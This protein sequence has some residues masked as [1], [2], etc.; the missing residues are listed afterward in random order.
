[1]KKMDDLISRQAAIDFINAGHL[2]NP[3]EPRWSDNE[4]MNFLKSRPPAEI[5]EEQAIDKLHETGWMQNHDKEMTNSRWIPCK[6]RL[7]E[8][9]GT[10]LTTT[11]KG[12][13]RVNHFHGK[14]WGYSND[15]VAWMPLPAPAEVEND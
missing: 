12:A 10:Y 15:A 7:P 2:V 4:V 11:I 13:V 1:M 5:T 6:E 8:E 14:Q 9:K 3:N